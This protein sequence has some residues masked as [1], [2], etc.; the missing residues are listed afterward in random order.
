MT[1][2]QQPQESCGLLRRPPPEIGHRTGA[3]AIKLAPQVVP[4]GEQGPALAADLASGVV[5]IGP[6]ARTTQA[7][8][9][10][11]DAIGRRTAGTRTFAAAA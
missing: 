8:P 4:L 10:R 6:S 7:L 5:Q 11:Q 2:S 9:G 3:T 1:A